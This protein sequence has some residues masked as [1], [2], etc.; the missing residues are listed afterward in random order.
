M[1]E[2]ESE[3]EEVVQ[4]TKKGKRYEKPQLNDLFKLKESAE[5]QKTV[6]KLSSDDV[7]MMKQLIAKYGD[8][9]DVRK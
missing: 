2:E 4:T 7:S 5:Y 6:K 1:E 8:N 9:F 3:E